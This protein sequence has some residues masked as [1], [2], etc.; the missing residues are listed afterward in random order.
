MSNIDHKPSKYMLNLQHV[1]P[2]YDDEAAGIVNGLVEVNTNSINKYEFIVESGQ[3]ALDRVGYSSLT[4]P[5]AYGLIPQTWDQDND[6][7]DFV[8]ANVTE[9]LVPGSLARCRVIGVMKFEDGG[10]RDDKIITVLAD[11]KRMDHIQSVADLGPHW[12]KETEHYF[13]HYKDLKK[14]GTCKVLGFEDIAAA[15]EV[16]KECAARYDAEY[17]PKLAD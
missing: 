16:I 10:E 3:L 5:V 6:L 9:P 14:P 7:L 11:D 13:E 17:R 8:I 4:Y 12:Q 1:L 15:R 2:P